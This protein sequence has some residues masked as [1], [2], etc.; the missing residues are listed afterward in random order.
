[1]TD[2]VKPPGIPEGS[3][4]TEEPNLFSNPDLERELQDPKSFTN[5][6]SALTVTDTD[7]SMFRGLAKVLMD[8]AEVLSKLPP[9]EAAMRRRQILQIMRIRHIRGASALMQAAI[10][11]VN[12]TKTGPITPKRE[13]SNECVRK[14]MV[15]HPVLG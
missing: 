11:E 10:R 8:I 14:S 15:K 13:K 4:V 12:S 5:R 6:I 9:L 7:P 3:P 2:E 1:M